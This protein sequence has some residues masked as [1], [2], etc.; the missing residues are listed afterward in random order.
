MLKA[1]KYRLY[2]TNKQK[3]LLT[4]TFGCVRY[5]WN[6]Q[7]EIFNSYNKET[8][9]TPIFKTSTE[10]RKEIEWLKEVSAAAI[11]QK[12][13]DFKEY[14]KQRFS[15][16]R[17]KIIAQPRFKSKLNKQSYRL[18]NQKFKVIDNRI[19]LEK[20]GKIKMVVDKPISKDSKLMSVTISKNPSGQ[21][22]ASVLVEQEIK[23]L[24]LTNKN[25]GI[26]VGLKEF[27]TQSDSI[28][29]ANP[30]YF[31]DSQ[32]KLAKM[33]RCHSRKKKGSNRRKKSRLKIAKL[34]Q[35]ITN[36]RDWFLHNETMRIVRDYDKICIEDLNVAGMVKNH[37]LAKSISDV[38]WSKFFSMLD[39]KCK[40]YGKELIK[41]DRFYPSS[42]TCGCGAINNN[43]KLADRVWTC[44]NCGA[45]NQRDLLAAQNIKALGVANAIQTQSAKVA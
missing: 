17:K 38:S 36:Q 35:Q 12:E 19:Q 27:L 33:Q 22:F 1:Y 23:R 28:T 16:K 44:S 29:I 8:N 40:W 13:I 2:P 24:L 45:V 4:K 31:C 7:V 34:H 21:F 25:V 10:Y 26:D 5:F 15:K 42:K 3:V 11:Q 32:M 6:K 20:I 39:Y 18:P 43:L 37:K 30:R 41:I 14:K 9:P